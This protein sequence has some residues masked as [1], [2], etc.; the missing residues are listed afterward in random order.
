MRELEL[1]GGMAKVTMTYLH[2]TAQRQVVIS[3]DAFDLVELGQVR[4]VDTF[5]AEH[6]VDREITR[7][8][9]PAVGSLPRRQLVQHLGA[10]CRRVCPQHQP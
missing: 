1:Y 5:V 9:W 10:D 2:K 4:R 7:R 6:S 8:R 3:N